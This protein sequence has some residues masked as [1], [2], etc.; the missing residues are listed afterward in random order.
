[1]NE[2]QFTSA[3][4]QSKNLEISIRMFV[5]E[6]YHYTNK[7]SNEVAVQLASNLLSNVIPLQY[8]VNIA[9]LNQ[10]MDYLNDVPKLIFRHLKSLD[11]AL[12]DVAN[13]GYSIHN[14]LIHILNQFIYTRQ[15]LTDLLN[16]DEKGVSVEYDDSWDWD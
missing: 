14:E 11:D 4:T 7:Q 12:E 2:L 9:Y 8:L 10:D 13:E 5:S 16:N 3:I 1:M 15:L 6:C